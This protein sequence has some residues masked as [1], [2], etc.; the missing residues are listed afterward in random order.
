MKFD[1]IIIRE[2]RGK[3][4]LALALLRERK[5]EMFQSFQTKCLSTEN[6]AFCT[7]ISFF[8]KRSADKVA[9]Y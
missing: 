8:G 3:Y 5:F 7:K 1:K 6:L 4:I 2:I 9:L